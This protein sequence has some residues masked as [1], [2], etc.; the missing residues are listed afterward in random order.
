MYS[1]LEQFDVKPLILISVLNID[2][3]LFDIYIPIMIIIMIYTYIYISL[4]KNSIVIISTNIQLLMEKIVEE[5]VNTIKNQIRKEG[6]KF[7][8]IIISLFLTI[9]LLNIISIF[10]FG[11]SL[12]SHLIILLWISILLGIACFCY[13][14]WL[15][16][17]EFFKLFIPDCPLVLLPVL[18]IIELFSYLIRC[19]S[20][21][22][23]LA[24]NM[25]AGHTLIMIIVLFVMNIILISIF[26]STISIFMLI[27]IILLEIGVCF[28]QAYVMTI[29]TCIYIKDIYVEGH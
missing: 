28:L 11:I 19:F 5:I 20:L 16:N 17:I 13:G 23:R 24:A 12:T 10:P 4:L 29:L 26:I 21:A 6:L 27:S 25:L 22:I 1:P 7:L 15:K 18:I 3:S 9:L 2:I 14:Y 8:P